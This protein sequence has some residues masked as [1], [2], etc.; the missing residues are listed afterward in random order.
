MFGRKRTHLVERAVERLAQSGDLDEL[1]AHLLEPDQ[2]AR[3]LFR[4]AP[5]A[6]T[7]VAAVLEAVRPPSGAE[8]HDD[9]AAALAGWDPRRAWTPTSCTRRC[10]RIGHR[11]W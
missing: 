4:P 3:S 11:R 10:S 1:S 6:V 5:S 8:L 2:Q 9:D 7:P